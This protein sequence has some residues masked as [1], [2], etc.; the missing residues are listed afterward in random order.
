[1]QKY[2]QL[3]HIEKKLFYGWK[4]NNFDTNPGSLF[5]YFQHY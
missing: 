1:M 2:Q 5:E 4:N 3:G